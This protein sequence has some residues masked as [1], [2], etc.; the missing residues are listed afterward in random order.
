MS[1]KPTVLY[2][3]HNHPSVR[4]GGAETYAYELF[5]A[6]R[7][8][9]EFDAV[10][11]AKAGPPI[12]T[13][14]RPFSG[15][16]LVSLGDGE[17]LFHTED[18]EYDWLFGTTEHTKDLSTKHFHELLESVQPEV[19]HFQHTLYFGYD[20]LR[21]VRNTLPAVPIV[22]TLH[23][24]LPICHHHGHFVRTQN[25]EL[26][27]DSAPRR[28]H[29]CFP[30]I[31]SQTFFMRKRFVQSQL[32]LVDMFLAPSRFLRQRYVDWGI[33]ADKIRFEEYGRAL[34]DADAASGPRKYRNRFGF[35]GQLNRF[36]GIFVLLKAMVI[37]RK[38]GVDA[39]L[40]IHGA[41]LDLQGEEFREDF[42]ALLEAAGDTV[43]FTGEYDASERSA[44]M[45]D[46]D[47]V[48]VP[49]IWWENSP[50]VIQEAFAHGRPVICSGVGG[51]AEKV[52]DGVNGI[53]FRRG[54]DEGLADAIAAAAG[55]ETLWDELREGIPEVYRMEDHVTMLSG[56]YRSLLASRNGGSP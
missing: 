18:Y 1:A 9:D 22:Y 24:Y 41:N 26:C 20:V 17:Y 34:G 50:L 36:K 30:D 47:W 27:L 6:M 52:A 15:T 2:V 35:F 44:L 32:A 38:R 3:C 46:V 55:S 42:D 21:E 39:H 12:S 10:F 53:H 7:E 25:D 40:G 16:V 31:S 45:Q 13:T 14:L 54:D 29:E 23:E 49:S 28:C 37:L 48:V 56:L 8:N 19:I 43:T 5:R 51:M 4:P 33:P 11:V